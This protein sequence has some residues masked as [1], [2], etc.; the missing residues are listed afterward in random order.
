MNRLAGDAQRV[1][2]L[3]PRPPATAR[4]QNLIGLHPLRQPPQCDCGAQSERRVIADN[5]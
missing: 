5:G 3:L 1:T 2:D 4:N